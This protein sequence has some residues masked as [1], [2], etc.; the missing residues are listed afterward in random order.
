MEG[1]REGGAKWVDAGNNK[2]KIYRWEE[3]LRDA[4]KYER[5]DKDRDTFLPLSHSELFFLR[6]VW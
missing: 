3:G 1:G 6:R 5:E 4:G 2:I